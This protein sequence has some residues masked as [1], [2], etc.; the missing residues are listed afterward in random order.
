MAWSLHELTLPF[1][2]TV[3][4]CNLQGQFKL[5]A[6]PIVAAVYGF[7]TSADASAIKRNRALFQELKQ[8]SVFIF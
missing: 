8:D 7:D 2:I 3:R 6:C 5:K 1:Q 4:T